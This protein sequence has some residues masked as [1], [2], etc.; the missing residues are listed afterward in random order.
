MKKSLLSGIAVLAFGI[1]HSQVINSFP[2]NEDFEGEGTGAASCGASYTMLSS[3]WNNDQTD[4]LDWEAKTGITTSTAT[5]PTANGGAD[6][7]PGTSTGHYLY[8]ETSGGCGNGVNVANLE[9]PWFD[10]STAATTE[11]SLWYH[12]YGA[13]MGT[14]H[15]DARTSLAGAW[16]LDIVTS[17]TDNVDAWQELVVNLAAYNSEDS[18][19]FRIRG[20]MGTSFESDMAIDDFSIRELLSDDVEATSVVTAPPACGLSNSELIDLTI[21]NVG[22]NDI[23]TGTII[24]VYYSINGGTPVMENMLIAATLTSGNSQTHTFTTL[25]DFSVPGSYSITAWA[26]MTGDQLAS[27]DTAFTSTTNIQV[28]SVPYSEDFESGDGFWTG[29]GDWQ[30]GV[31]SGP[32]INS[33]PACGSGTN[34]WGTNLTGDYS[35]NSND[36]VESICMD[37]SGITVDPILSFNLFYDTETNY[38]EGW[39]EYSFDGGATWTKLGAAG[40]GLNWYNNAA[41]QYWEGN[42]GGWLL[43]A[44]ELTGFAGQSDVKLRF[45][46]SSDGSVTNDGFAFDNISIDTTSLTD[47]STQSIDGPLSGCGLTSAESIMA[48]FISQGSDTIIGFDACYTIDGGTQICETVNDTLFPGVPYTYTFATTADLSLAVDYT[49]AVN[50]S[51]AIDLSVCNNEVSAI[52]SNKPVISSFPY[53]ET[54]ENGSGGWSADNTNNG[55]WELTTPAGGIINSAASGINAWVTNA[56]GNYSNNDNSS[57]YGPCF[58]FTN[59]P[60]GSWVVMKTWWNSEFSWDGA[61]L[62]LSVDDGANWVNVGVFGDPDNWFTDNSI[63]GLGFSGNQE[64]WSGRNSSSNGSG[65]WVISKHAL[66][67]SLIGHNSV[68]FRVNFGSDGSVVDEGFA[69]D[70][71]G[72][73]VPPTV[74]IGADFTG[75]GSYQVTLSGE[76]TF[77]WF[78]QDTAMVNPPV[79]FNTG[80]TGTF[81]NT[82]STDTTYYGIVVFTDTIGLCASDTALLTLNPAPYNQLPDTVVCPGDTTWF[83]ADAD[84]NH[85]YNWSNF[86]TT[87]SSAFIFAPNTT[88]GM[89][90]VTTTN[91]TNNCSHTDTAMVM[92]TPVVSINDTAFCAGDSVM[93]DAGMDYVMWNWSNGD[94]T[95]MTTTATAGMISVTVTDGIGCVSM[96]SAMVTSNAVPTPS[97]TGASD[98]LCSLSSFTLD[99]GSFASYMWSTGG[100]AQAESVDGPTLGLGT[101]TVTVTVMD[102]NGCAGMDSVTFEVVQ[103]TSIDENELSLVSVYPNPTNGLFTIELM[104]TGQ[105]NL[106]LTDVQGKIIASRTIQ[107]TENID[108]TELETGIYFL[109]ASNNQGE[110]VLRI[111]KN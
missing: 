46:F 1:S 105:L 103:C 12:M 41:N 24:P 87:D 108:I 23:T 106:L 73:G 2:Y 7:N 98:T 90:I 58:D 26:Q 94:S 29:S 9:T 4:D 43:A 89:V 3:G 104:N 11:L 91:F 25:A 84:P 88:G 31:P 51:A 36:A 44:H 32:V 78:G 17:L 49:I 47:V 69:F 111:V 56:N 70:D 109:T 92:Q 27:N 15:L 76:G 75:C 20:I 77:E 79:L 50:I 63:S 16:T 40:Q 10:F 48:T 33:A 99:A 13:T 101:Q 14:M 37:F 100:T 66:D 57:V 96:D 8:T 30:H 61:N 110:Q 6:H 35:N 97:I 74:D 86:L 81:P 19:Q 102:A 34:V 22:S 28:A 5:G 83:F 53:Y 71:F 42:S 54:F 38:D 39:V 18:V 93:I 64:G 80:T 67:D 21:T 52:V 85:L 72:I 68:Q 62:Q 60:M 95:Q 65:G 82:G 55:T 107:Q 59:L 45:F